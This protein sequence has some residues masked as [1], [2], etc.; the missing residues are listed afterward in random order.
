MKIIIA[1]LIFSIIIII[2]ELGHFLLAKLNGVTVLEFSVGMGPRLLSIKPGG[3]RYSLRILPFGGSCMMLGEDGEDE[4]E[5]SFGSKS[6]WARISVIAA[7]PVF[8]FLLA[9]VLSLFIVGNIGYD[10]PVLLQVSDGLPAQEAGLQEGDRIVKMNGKRIHLYRE[11]Q[12][13]GMFHPG[14]TVTF[15]YERDGQRYTT[16][17]EPKLTENGYK[18]GIVGSVNYRE[19]TGIL[20][21]LKYSAYEV[22]YWID[23]TLQSLKMLFGGG[24]TLNDLSGPVGVV[25][26]IGD[27]YEESRSEGAMIMWLNLINIAILLTANLGVMNL[28]PIPALDGGRLVFLI[29]EAI[30]RKRLDPELEAKIHLA[31]LMLLMILMVVVMANDIKKIVL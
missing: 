26:V 1:L 23:T 6:V 13:Y 27:T 7:G 4:G 18:Y 30:R 20:G 25:D 28:L 24:V 29:V 15:E 21:T 17:V 31:G 22:Y 14:K 9:F 11:V 12:N 3:T 16:T 10:L 8:N 2:H 5:G 19:R